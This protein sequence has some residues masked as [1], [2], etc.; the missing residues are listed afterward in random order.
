M[1]HWGSST[2]SSQFLFDH[3][4]NQETVFSIPCT[5][6]KQVVLNLCWITE[7]IDSLMNLQ[8]NAHIPRQMCTETQ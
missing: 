1:H 3:L 5:L 6:S 7:P 8:T 2:F 4:T